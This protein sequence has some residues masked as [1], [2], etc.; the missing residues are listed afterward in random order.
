[1]TLDRT[2]APHSQPI[3]QV[4]LPHYDTQTL[5]NRCPLYVINIGKQPVMRLEIIFE[6]SS[7]YETIPSSTFFM[8]KML[9][10]GTAHYSSAQISDYFDQIGAFLEISPTADQLTLVVYGLPKHLEAILVM[11]CEMLTAPTF[12]T[13]ELND[14]KNIT[15]QNLQLNLEKNG[16]V[17]STRFRERL[18]GA[19]HPYGRSQNEIAVAAIERSQLVEAHQKSIQNK[20]FKVFLSGLVADKETALVKQYLGQL[21]VEQITIEKPVFE[22]VTKTE[23]LLITKEDALQSSLR[24]GRQLFTRN[25]PDYFKFSVTNEVLGGYFG[26]RLMKNIRENKGYTYGISSSVAIQR[27]LGYF[28]INTDVKKEVAEATLTEI[29]KEITL[30]QTQLVTETEL[31]TVKNFMAGAMAGSLNTPFE[32]ADRVRLTILNNLPSD[33]YEKY[34]PNIRAVTNQQILETANQ[35]YRWQDLLQVVVG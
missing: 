28:V 30:L 31:Q 35:Y 13:K 14:L 24:I 9:S 25:H 10:E 15:A 12:P 6:R 2:L 26:S 7:W 23:A 21:G 11:V 19:H 33:F 20:P 8:A 5:P 32:V 27:E 22:V 4:R 16:Y 1:M 17:A 29:Q 18:L 3:Q 34:I